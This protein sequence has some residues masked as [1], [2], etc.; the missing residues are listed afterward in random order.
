MI[1]NIKKWVIAIRLWTLTAAIIPITQ[2]AVLA[3]YQGY[4]YKLFPFFLTLLA[5]IFLQAAS[6]LLNTYGDY[7]SGVDTSETKMTNRE[8]IEGAIPPSTIKNA[9]LL[10]VALAFC[11]G[12]YLIYI[13]GIV[14]FVFG[15][16]GIL[17]TLGYTTGRFP[18]KYYGLGTIFVFFL[19][20]SFMVIPAYYIQSSTLN[21]GVFL[22]SIPVSCLVAMI[23]L[24]NEIRDI[25]TD[26]K[27]NIRTLAINLG[28]EKA[29]KLYT[30]LI[31]ASYAFLFT[32]VIKGIVPN[33]ALI[34]IALIPM[35]FTKME[36]LEAPAPR[37]ELVSLVKFGAKAHFLFGI[38]LIIGVFLGIGIRELIRI[39]S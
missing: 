22:Y 10:L 21:I 6:N 14:V 30:Y 23:L 33:T 12:L 26:R 28:Q 39:T 29:I 19:M 32:V 3:W 11:L 36:K 35:F 7:K 15:L 13:S 25:E 9:A 2:G 8:I 1:S 20:G 31:I 17:G 38:L 34:P 5:G 4:S 24:G 16:L 37:E 27:A 18:F